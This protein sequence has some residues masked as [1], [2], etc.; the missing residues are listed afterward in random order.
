[1]PISTQTSGLWSR[2]PAAYRQL[3]KVEVIKGVMES[4]SQ[5]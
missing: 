3:Q 1:M 4:K 2:R 5:T